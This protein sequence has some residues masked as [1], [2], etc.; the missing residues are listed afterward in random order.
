MVSFD[1]YVDR[2]DLQPGRPR[3]VVGQS[4]CGKST[5]LDILSFSLVPQHV[6]VFQLSTPRRT[7]D[8]KTVSERTPEA[9]DAIRGR[10]MGYVLQQGG[11]LP[12]LTVRENICFAA[13]LF[14]ISD[15]LDV[16]ELARSLNLGLCLDKRPNALSIGERQRAGIARAVFHR[17]GILIADEPTASVDV[18]NAD[19]IA[20][21]LLGVSR[22][23]NAALIVATHDQRIVNVMDLE[24]LELEVSSSGSRSTSRFTG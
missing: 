13:E 20:E 3:A 17:P 19:Q 9:L 5:L 21:L 10:F 23:I 7:Y 8:I 4:G 12:F 14:E 24:P 22:D 6:D 18:A 16:D 11:L 2:L 15:T 1:L